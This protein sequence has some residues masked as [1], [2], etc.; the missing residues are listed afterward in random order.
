MSTMVLLSCPGV[1]LIL[2]NVF[3]FYGSGFV[4]LI[5]AFGG[6]FTVNCVDLV[7]VSG[8]AFLVV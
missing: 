1:W 8:S 6:C 2:S 4:S 3:V 5:Y 7:Y